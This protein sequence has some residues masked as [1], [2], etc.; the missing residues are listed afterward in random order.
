MA[1]HLLTDLK[2]Q[3][4][5]A[6]AKGD[7]IIKSGRRKGQVVAKGY[8][9]ADGD[10]LYL[11]VDETGTKSWQLRYS[12]NGKRQTRT[13]G[14]LARFSLSQARKAADVLRDE[15]AEGRHLTV[16]KRVTKAKR[17]ANAKNTFAAVAAD[18]VKSEARQ[19]AWSTAYRDEVES[20]LR[21]HLSDLD[22]LPLVE[23][24]APVAAP[25]LRKVELAAPQMLEKVRRRLRCILD[26]GVDQG[27]I[28]VNPLPA[29]RRVRRKDRR[30]FPAVT[31]LSGL[32]AILRAANASDPCKGIRRAHALLAFTAMRVS[33]VVGATW[34]EFSLDGVDVAIGDGR[35]KRDARAGNWSI[36]RE[37]MK[38]KDEERGPH[39]VPLPPMLLAALREWRKADGTDTGYVCPAPRD[40]AKP[41]TAEAV[42]KHYRNALDLAGKHSP[43]SWRSAFSTVAREVGKDGDAIEAQLDHVVG[44]KVSSAYDRARR[45]EL[46]R[47]LMTW[48]EG[49]LVAA[50]DG[51][52]VLP[53]RLKPS[54]R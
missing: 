43:H 15:A 25:V 49:A 51:A 10:N 45:V 27:V 33:E 53:M 11:W 39:V 18:W 13:I 17:R 23:V 47:P 46:R 6:G 35:T 20:S 1:R 41:I 2:V 37:R 30:H 40:A 36:P 9:L 8:R 16:E 54:K 12:H 4:A 42:E 7:H 3:K 34:A 38:R 44:N 29:P 5:K 28:V 32:G 26:Y 19:A 31:E 24:T 21:N 14:K 52:A 48:Y 50:R 22:G